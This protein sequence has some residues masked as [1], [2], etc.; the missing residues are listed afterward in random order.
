[1]PSRADLYSKKLGE[2]LLKGWKM[3]GETCP[4]TDEVPLMQHPVTGRKFS[5]ATGMY[6]DEMQFNED[7]KLM[8]APGAAEKAHAQGIGAADAGMKLGDKDQ[9]SSTADAGMELDNKDQGNGTAD[10]SMKL[11]DKNQTQTY[12]AAATAPRSIVHI[13]GT[14]NATARDES[15]DWCVPAHLGASKA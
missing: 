9:G 13:N 6:V 7:G 2:L 1:M 3:L 14:E 12:S 4:A 15:D 5:I 11:D 10:A 8:N